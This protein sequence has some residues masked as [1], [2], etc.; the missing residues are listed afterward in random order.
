MRFYWGSEQCIITKDGL[1]GDRTRMEETSVSI[2]C[3]DC[4][5]SFSTTIS[6]NGEDTRMC[7]RLQDFARFLHMECLL[8]KNCAYNRQSLLAHPEFATALRRHNPKLDEYLANP[9][10]PITTL[11]LIGSMSTLLYLRV[12]PDRGNLIEVGFTW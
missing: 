4:D 11:D 6:D 2:G 9:D 7:F 3:F 1:A 5:S 8:P 10:H 12:H